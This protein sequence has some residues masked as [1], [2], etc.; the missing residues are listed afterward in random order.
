M[1]TI[2]LNITNYFAIPVKLIGTEVQTKIEKCL[3]F[4][5]QWNLVDSKALK[6]TMQQNSVCLRQVEYALIPCAARDA[7]ENLG[8]EVNQLVTL[9]SA[10]AKTLGSTAGMPNLFLARAEDFPMV[11]GDIGAA[12]S[13]TIPLAPK[14]RRGVI[15]VFE[16]PAQGDIPN[17]LIATTD[18]E[19]EAGSSS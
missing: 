15:L 16:F 12:W 11:N 5:L 1:S 2:D 8:F 4:D 9:F 14:T 10:N 6:D 19:V 3:Y 17:Q 7:V 13:V 18:P